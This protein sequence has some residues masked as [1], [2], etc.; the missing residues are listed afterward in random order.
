MAS[1]VLQVLTDHV[2]LLL[3]KLPDLCVKIVEVSSLLS[4]NDCS[5]ICNVVLYVRIVTN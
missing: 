1:H 5:L 4:T 2:Q 3:D